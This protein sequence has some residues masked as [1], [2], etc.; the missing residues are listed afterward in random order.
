MNTV[1][2]KYVDVLRVCESFDSF[3]IFSEIESDQQGV[4]MGDICWK[5]EV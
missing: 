1:A 4:R 5:T 2:A 3:C